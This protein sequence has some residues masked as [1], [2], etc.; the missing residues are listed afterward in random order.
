[1]PS[2]VTT[3]ATVHAR[4]R[5]VVAVYTYLGGAIVGFV[6]FQAML[7]GTGGAERLAEALLSVPGGWLVVLGG[8]MLVAWIATHVARRTVRPAA[9]LLALTGFVGAEAVIFVPLLWIASRAAPG[10]TGQAAFLTL[11]GM[12]ALTGVVALTRWDFAFLRA[13]LLWS[14]ALA[15]LV[16]VAAVSY[17]VG[18]GTWFAAGMILL[19]GGSILYDTARILRPGEPT[20]PPAAAALEL[21]SSAALLFWYVL[22][23]LLSRVDELTP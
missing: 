8:Y 17:G 20:P 22:E 9:Q 2:Q 21:F 19:A 15:L 4:T 1:M 5:F 3:A 16:I 23:F 18:L 13:F 10:V 12:A 7:F 6:G 14:G 11:T